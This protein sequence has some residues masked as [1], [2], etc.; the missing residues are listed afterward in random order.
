MTENTNKRK[1]IVGLFVS[2]GTVF[3]IAGIMS[4]GNLHSTFSKKLHIVAF[5]KD[6]SGLQSGNNIWFSGVK[7]GTVKKLEFQP[8]NTVKVTMNLNESA[9]EYI[10]KDAMVKVGTDGLIGNKIL[11]IY[12]GSSRVGAVEDGDRLVTRK[13]LETEDLLTTLQENNSNLLEITKDLKIVSRKLSSG[14][15]TLGKLLT[16][17]ALFDDLRNTTMSLNNASNQAR[18]LLVSL[19]TFGSSLNKK[20][21]LAYDLVNDTILYKSFTNSILQLEKMAADAQETIANLKQASQNPATPLG[22]LIYDEKSGEQIKTIIQNLESSSQK[23]DED[24]KALQSN[25]FFRRYFKN[26]DK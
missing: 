10:R 9:Q 13:M 15:G 5:F 8:D 14:E 7:I 20:G 1:V 16:D 18:Q 4:I 25:I 6:V 12:G 19:T 24:L 2:I 21:T 22:V 17:E 11:I 26:K 3:L 23:L